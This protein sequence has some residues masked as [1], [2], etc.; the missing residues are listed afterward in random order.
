M[1]ITNDNFCLTVMKELDQVSGTNG[2]PMKNRQPAGL[3]EALTSSQNTMG[4]EIESEFSPGDGR[5]HKVILKHLTPDAIADVTTTIT[6][7][8]EETGA[9]TT[10]SY[11]EVEIANQVQG[12]VKSMTE[13]EMRGWC[14]EGNDMRLRIIAGGM[15]ALRK[16]I[17]QA[18]IPLFYSGVGGILGGN[19]ARGTQYQ[20]LYRDGLLMVDPEGQIEMMRDLQDTGMLGTPIV[21]GGSR[22]DTWA[23]LS[24]IAC[25][26]QWGINPGDMDALSFYYDNDISSIQ[27]PSDD[28]AFFVFAPGAA[29]FVP[30]PQFVGQFRKIGDTF[31][32]D[33]IVDPVT[34]LTFDYHQSYDP[35]GN[36]NNGSYKWMLSLNFG[37][38]QMPLDLFKSTDN[39]YKV[40]YNFSFQ[41][42]EGAA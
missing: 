3:L 29:Q 21:V 17:N 34:G 7:F 38:W 32:K 41:I 10:W 37:L 40:N 15:N 19:G 23:K 22:M 1:A 8:C 6:D 5:N 31:I 13:A 16:K 24:N 25:C 42:T 27:G 33:T 30:K 20:M 28:Q 14:E 11:D 26:N 18:L 4:T 9:S 36:N 35:C 39:R 2:D 12:P